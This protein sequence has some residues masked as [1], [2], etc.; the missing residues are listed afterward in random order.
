MERDFE[1]EFKQ[2][3]QDEIPDLWNR[4]EAGLSEKQPVKAAPKI[5]W[6]K[7]AALAAAIVCLIIVLPAISLTVIKGSSMSESTEEFAAEETSIAEDACA[8]EEI[9][10]DEEYSMVESTEEYLEKEAAEE[11]VTEAASDEAKPSKEELLSRSFEYN[12]FLEPYKDEL[13][14]IRISA[15]FGNAEL[16]E[17]EDA[18]EITNASVTKHYYL[19][20]DIVDNAQVGD[21]I[22]IQGIGYTIQA[23]EPSESGYDVTLE[24]GEKVDI[25][26]YVYPDIYAFERTKDGEHYVILFCSDDYI[27]EEI[28]TGSVFFDKDCIFTGYFQ[29]EICDVPLSEY[30]ELEKY[31]YIS[32]MRFEITKK[33]LI[34]AFENQIAG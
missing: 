17:R 6:R 19:D 21:V 7:W 25:S 30:Y 16:I 3:K 10:A 15:Y 33:G 27:T 11:P 4:I 18:I 28:Y 24:V 13:E 8:A 23:M 14:Y 31:P 12:E 20:A 1:Q 5:V 34:Q 32:I 9:T 29:G 22:D 26:Q 2:L